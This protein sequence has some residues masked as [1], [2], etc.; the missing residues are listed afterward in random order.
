MEER[1]SK[2]QYIASSLKFYDIK[3]PELP[4]EIE[5][6][7]PILEAFSAC[8]QSLQKEQRS[9]GELSEAFQRIQVTNKELNQA[10][11]SQGEKI[12][13][14][15]CEISRLQ[16]TISVNALKFKQER[17]KLSQEKDLAKKEAAKAISLCT[18][19]F[20]DSKKHEA[21]YNKLQEHLRKL[22]SEKDLPIKNSLE[23]TNSLHKQG[24]SLG[25]KRADE[26]LLFFIKTGYQGSMKYYSEIIEMLINTLNDC[27]IGI[28]ELLT[29]T[30]C[31]VNWN[32]LSLENPERFKAEAENRLF[33]FSAAVK[34]VEKVKEDAE[35]PENTVG[36]LKKVLQGYK[37]VIDSNIFSLI[38][39]R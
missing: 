32:P 8:L 28:K 15:E 14:L 38:R 34:S 39:D 20:H 2:I 35:F 36:Q 17:E 4:A 16:N 5:N 19:H 11:E 22:L 13:E 12:H 24:I 33:Q 23:C 21:A 30:G 37:E 18:Q 6:F 10:S 26:E 1:E 31:E 3:L 7:D 27:F 9:K 29:K 25:Q